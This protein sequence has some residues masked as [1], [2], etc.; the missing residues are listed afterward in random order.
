[1]LRR[2]LIAL[3]ATSVLP[4][5]SWAQSAKPLKLVVPF[6]PGGATDITARVLADPLSRMLGQ[7]VIVDNRGGAGGSIGMTEVS[8]AAPD[9]LT[10]GVATLSTH[11]VNPA[12]YAKL[13]YDPIKDF[14]A[15]TEL[16]KAPGVVVVNAA[17]PVKNYAEL[18]AYLKANPGK[19]T[20]A[21][22]GNGTIGHM[23]GELF[24]STTNT[25]MVHIPYRGSGPALNDVVA[26]QVQVYFDQV[27]SSLPF[28]QSGKLRA[29]AVSWNKR[30]DVLPNTPTYAE[31][32][33][34]SNNDPSWFGL[35][36]PAGTPASA[37]NRIQQ[38]VAKALQEPAVRARL[39]AQGLFA[40][41]TLPDEFST[42]IRKEIDKMQRIA[43]FAKISL[44]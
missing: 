34:F 35:V 21:S 16:V 38:A 41:G 29:I 14:V 7:P 22:P 15:V 12:V 19:V 27:A 25:F 28:I 42:Q 10:L 44:D 8:R 1:M 39:A 40:S 4:G 5:L 24:K 20:Y 37:V 26:G 13:P 6:P 30:L 33:L 32:S 43:K 18:I 31:L 9:G 36:A 23:W 11:G 17:M 2:H 3:T